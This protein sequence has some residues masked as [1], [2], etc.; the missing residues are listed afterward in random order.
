MNFLCLGVR[1]WVS[2]SWEG[3]RSLSS[4]GHIVSAAISQV[5]QGPVLRKP[6]KAVFYA[7]ES[8]IPFGRY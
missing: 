3:Q 6:V 7:T 2:I 5:I 8:K 4:A 1:A